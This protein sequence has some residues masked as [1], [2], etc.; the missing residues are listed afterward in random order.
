MRTPRKRA[1]A[2]RRSSASDDLRNHY[3]FDYSKA[4]ANRFAGRFSRESVIV[5]LEPDVANVFH[6]SEAVNA[7]LRSA[8]EAMP[9]AEQRKRK[10]AS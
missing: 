2:P 5:V 1:A 6:T 3:D 9:Q 7:F 4:R 8:I 10:R